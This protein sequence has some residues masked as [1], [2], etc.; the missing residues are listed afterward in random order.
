MP[1]DEPKPFKEDGLDDEQV[2]TRVITAAADYLQPGSDNSLQPGQ[3]GFYDPAITGPPQ[4]HGRSTG[5]DDRHML[6]QQNPHPISDWSKV[7]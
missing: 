1:N 7:A 3:P 5:Q 4:P 2:K 6:K